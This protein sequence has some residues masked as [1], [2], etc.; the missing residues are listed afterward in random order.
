[1]LKILDDSQIVV[2]HYGNRALADFQFVTAGLSNAGNSDRYEGHVRNGKR[3]GYGRLTKSSGNTFEGDVRRTCSCSASRV[4][5]F[6]EDVPEG[7]GVMVFKS[8]DQYE[9]TLPILRAPCHNQRVSLL[10]QSSRRV[11]IG[12][13]A[14]RGAAAQSGRPPVHWAVRERLRCTSFLH[15]AS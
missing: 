8:G 15:C 3:H 10:P 13:G 11:Q 12:R 2:I 9:G 14:R 1:M 4:V 5:Q 6:C 7:R